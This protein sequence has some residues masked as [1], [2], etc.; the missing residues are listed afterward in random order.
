MNSKAKKFD[1]RIKNDDERPAERLPEAPAPDTTLKIIKKES[2]EKDFFTLKE[3][4]HTEAIRKK[5]Y[6][7]KNYFGV[8]NHIDLF[9]IGKKYSDLIKGGIKSLAFIGDEHTV[10]THHTLLGIASYFNYHHDC[11]VT[12]LIERFEGSELQKFLT[13]THLE[14]ELINS[15]DANTLESYSC[16]GIDIVEISRLRSTLKKEGP[17]VLTNFLASLVASAQVVLWDLPQFKRIDSEKEFYLPLIESVQSLS[18]I[19]H[20]GFSK[21]EGIR[22]NY[23]CAKKYQM[24]VEGV[25]FYGRNKI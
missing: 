6:N 1:F 9:E 12:I 8:K 20:K 24:R 25:L 21:Q 18:L 23:E 14:V 5:T 2:V 16:E 11:K 3:S 7:S 17:E 4:K 19:V 15:D 13:P 22:S 10:S